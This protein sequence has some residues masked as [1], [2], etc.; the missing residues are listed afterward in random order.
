[1]TFRTVRCCLCSLV[2]LLAFLVL[3]S[4]SPGAESEARQRLEATVNAVLAELQKPELQNPAT[5]QQVLASVEKI[6]LTLFDFEELSMR[7]V[8]PTWRS[9]SDDQK[10][11][12]QAAFTNLLRES[13]LEKL[14]GYNGE[15]VTYLGENSS[16]DGK[17]AEIQT[18]VDVM[19]KPVPVAYRMIRKNDWVVYD[20]IIE[21]V[22]MVQNYR[23]QFQDL[24]SR[25]SIEQLIQLVDGKAS[26]VREI[27]RRQ[28]TAN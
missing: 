5:Q 22:S 13:Y 18:S 4:P 9:F 2:V 21:G 19:G 28:R 14:N 25:G 8:G 11:R 7:T 27:N 17:R 23:T 15:T 26:E 10:T 24:L 3:P 1:M 20:M 6:I 12:F 16:S